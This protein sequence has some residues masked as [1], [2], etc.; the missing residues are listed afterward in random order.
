MTVQN[1]PSETR[2]G[3]GTGRAR[4]ARGSWGA[5][6]SRRSRDRRDRR[7]GRDI[8]GSHIIIVFEVSDKSTHV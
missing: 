5:R 7:E 8:G 3:Q 2:G 6:R 4:R 1:I